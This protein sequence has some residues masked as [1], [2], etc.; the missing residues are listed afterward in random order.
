MSGRQL[1]LSWAAQDPT[2]STELT[3]IF[4]SMCQWCQRTLYWGCLN[5]I[6]SHISGSHVLVPAVKEDILA[7]PLVS[8]G[9][10][11]NSVPLIYSAVM[12]STTFIY[13]CECHGVLNSNLNTTCLGS[14]YTQY[15]EAVKK[16]CELKIH[17]TGEIV[18]QLLN[19]WYLVYSPSVQ[20][21]PISCRNDTQS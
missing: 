4:S 15:F 13:L 3:S 1:S 5:Y 2:F 18:Y 16:L 11:P 9:T 20:T 17:K 12:S 10:Q 14:L 19:N 7:S 6:P 8:K 21:V